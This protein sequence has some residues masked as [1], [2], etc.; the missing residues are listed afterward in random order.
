MLPKGEREN[1]DYRAEVWRTRNPRG[2]VT[3]STFPNHVSIY[4]R[5]RDSRHL[6]YS[7]SQ[8]PYKCYL[9]YTRRKLSELLSYSDRGRIAT[10]PWVRRK[11]N[12]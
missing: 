12:S 1:A 6:I 2:S 5:G 3:A 11:P 4:R 7:L 8:G 9:L 10:V